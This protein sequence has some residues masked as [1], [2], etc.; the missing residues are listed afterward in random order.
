MG[1]DFIIELAIFAAVI[2]QIIILIIL[3]SKNRHG[4]QEHVLQ[5]FIEYEKRLDKNE[6]SMRDE[7]GRNRDETN[8]SAKDAREELNK[9]IYTFESKVTTSISSFSEI[10]NKEL[11]SVQDTVSQST[12]I[13]R[14]ELANSLKSF[15]EK[16]SAKIETLTRDTNQLLEKNRETVEKKLSDIQKENGEK[17]EKMRETVDEKLHKTLE[18]RLGE[19]F[20]LVSERLELVQKGLGEMQSLATGVGDLKKV[21]SNVKTKGVLGE[22][23][24]AAI[25]EQLLSPSQ[26][27][28]NVATKTGS[29]DNVEFAVKIPS[30]DDSDKI[31]WLPIDSK[32]PTV[33]Y[34]SLMDAYDNGAVEIIERSKKELETKI[35]NFAKDIHTK[36][37]DPPNTT[38]FAIMFLP[39]EGLYAEVLRIPSL[40]EFIQS[41]YKVTITG[42]TTISAFLNSLQM[43]FRSLAVEKRTSE[44]WNVLGAV[45]TEFGKFGD[46]LDATKKKLDQAS[47]E[48]AKTGTRTRQIEKKL[49]DFEILPDNEAQKLLEV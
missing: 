5:K 32:F 36:Y 27:A 30:K 9:S 42:P 16:F 48:L 29:R 39:F 2:I 22:Y 21:L 12:R 49:K 15:E 34:E 11:K 19:S 24:L 25:L 40:F 35:K 47:D 31:V 13:S 14:E 23:Q 6:S 18:T 46:I 20:K 44:I 38:E 43:G 26:Y 1:I 10:L 4:P 8:K 28:E 3:F 7:F 41:T 45:R 37:I 17:L 33:D